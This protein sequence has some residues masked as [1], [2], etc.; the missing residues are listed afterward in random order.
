M[1]GLNSND[2][3]IFYCGQGSLRRNRV[4]L[5]Q[6]QKKSHNAVLKNTE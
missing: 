3:C 5:P 4:T 1:G 6:S 2:D